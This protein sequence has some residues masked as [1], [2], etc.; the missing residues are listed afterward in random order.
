MFK[1][2]NKDI[3]IK[4]FNEVNEVGVFIGTSEYTSQLLLVLEFLIL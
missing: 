1:V 2:S 3:K 4:L